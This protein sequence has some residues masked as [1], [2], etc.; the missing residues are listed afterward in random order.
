MIGRVFC[1]KCAGKKAPI[2]HL[3]ERKPVRICDMCFVPLCGTAR[4]ENLA[5]SDREL[6][7]PLAEAH[8]LFIVSA[9]R[10][11]AGDGRLAHAH[12]QG[13][14]HRAWCGHLLRH[15]EERPHR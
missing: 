11:V 4:V 2:A 15:A 1:W 7:T 6:H 14:S 8:L 13:V 3:G 5:L 10:V 12:A 9:Q